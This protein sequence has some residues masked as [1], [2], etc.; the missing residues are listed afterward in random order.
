MAQPNPFA[1]F[2]G[3]QPND[4][5][6]G[7]FG[8]PVVLAKT[9]GRDGK[10]I[11]F[12]VP[13]DANDETV[14]A[15]A[16]K[17][18]GDPRTRHINRNGAA[19]LPPARRAYGLRDLATSKMTLG[20]TDKIAPMIDAGFDAMSGKP[21]GESYQTAQA[22]QDAARADYTSKHKALD[23]ATL[24]L[25]LFAGGG[26]AG[27]VASATKTGLA[28]AGA[29]FGLLSG[30]GNSRGTV[31][32]QALQTV[33][34]TATGAVLAPVIGAAATKAAPAIGR[35]ARRVTGRPVAPQPSAA[36]NIIADALKDQGTT[37]Q[38]VGRSIQDARSKGVPLALMDTGDETRGLAS[39]LA[40][41]PG[42]NRTL[43][44]DAVIA[45]QEG[46]TER[47]QGAIKRDLGPTANVREASERL[48]KNA[49]I[50][51]APLYDKAYASPVPDSETLKMLAG[52][53]SMRAALKRA[54]GIASEEGRDPKVMGFNLDAE[55]NV[56]L[57]KHNS[58]QTW[59]Y[60]KRGLDDVIESNRDSTTGR[61]VL[62]EAGRATN[63]T[64]AAL[65]KEI[66]RLNPAY[67]EAR[68]AY[69][70][71][72]SMAS[73]LRKG[74]KVA[75]KDAET[76]LAETRDL[77]G[78]ETEQY[79][80]GARSA[81]SKM[82]EGRVDGA[83]KV[84]ALIGTPKKRSALARLFGGE[85]GLDNLLATLAHEGKTSATYGRVNTGSQTAANLA[86]DASLEGLSGVAVNA[87]GRAV[88][89]HGMTSNAIHTIGD[90]L[91]YGA[92]KKGEAL[93]SQL[94]VGLSE[95]RP[96]VLSA[97][98][99]SAARAGAKQRIVGKIGKRVAPRAGVASG[100][101]A[102]QTIATLSGNR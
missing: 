30:I 23:W 42:P 62:D 47:V 94:A 50:K 79:R 11:S 4:N 26:A 32:E 40:R 96:E 54:Y 82:L 102:G 55:G 27:T 58:T 63:N 2:G 91:R 20:L 49:Q 52:R 19:P 57:E 65:L 7:Q 84:R 101:I 31:G 12:E 86:D 95:T 56:T 48:I 85:K 38:Q 80:L 28:K 88:R 41:K 61:L 24:P 76:I 51:A 66:D 70:G 72:A 69:A 17:A 60:V 21:F 68:Q 46:Q 99:K 18:T 90:L 43:M 37:P 3:A 64:R 36:G 53:P 92:G 13:A 8:G 73:A 5:P 81:L 97:L 6:F 87:A 45:R 1:Q 93:R 100:Q 67:G 75:N 71:P 39:S 15:A 9:K 83:D 98:V 14:Q 25:N 59:D 89:G 29:G 33:G 35:L 74:E 44:R 78:P 77:T 34:S 16:R 22:Q 10:T